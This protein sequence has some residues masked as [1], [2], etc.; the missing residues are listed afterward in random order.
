MVQW[1]RLCTATPG[2]V[3][4]I[5]GPGTK[6]LHAVWHGQ[7][8]TNN[9]FL[10]NTENP[11]EPC[12]GYGYG[13]LPYS[14]VKLRH[15]KY[16][17]DSCWYR[18]SLVAQLVKNPPA[19]QEILVQF[20]GWEDSPG[21]GNNYPFQYSGLENSMDFIIQ[22]VTKSLTWLS[23]F[24]DTTHTK[25]MLIHGKNYHNIAVVLQLK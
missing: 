17:A 8:K 12:V 23:D 3:G 19:I 14:K 7:I 11:T 15:S 25:H 9:L 13:H 16:L 2:S 22:G 4:L 20:V 10:K 24:T 5:P 6:T 1:L 21:E 18:A